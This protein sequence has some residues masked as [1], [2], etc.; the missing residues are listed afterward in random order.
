MKSEYGPMGHDDFVDLF[1]IRLLGRLETESRRP[2]EA[3]TAI[4]QIREMFATREGDGVFRAWMVGMNPHLN[5][6]NP[7]LEIIAGNTW[8]VM[9]AARAYMQGAVSS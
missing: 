6:K 5:D 1:G 3:L 4:Q 7:L 2:D 8:D 9:V